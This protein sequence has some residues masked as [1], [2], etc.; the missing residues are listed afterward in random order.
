MKKVY[1][2]IIFAVV[3]AAIFL[4][5]MGVKKASSQRKWAT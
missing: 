4:Y 5:P 3:L 2:I 1:I